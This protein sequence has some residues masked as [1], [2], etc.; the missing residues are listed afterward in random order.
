MGQKTGQRRY[1]KATTTAAMRS[2]RFDNLGV[3]RSFPDGDCRTGERQLADSAQIDLT[4][5]ERRD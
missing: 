5:A 1:P 4:G 3:L 2:P